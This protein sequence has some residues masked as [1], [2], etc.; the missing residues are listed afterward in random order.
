MKNFA[1]IWGA[2]AMILAPAVLFRATDMFIS[3][4][5]AEFITGYRPL[6]WRITSLAILLGGYVLIPLF[7]VSHARQCLSALTKHKEE[8]DH[9]SA[10]MAEMENEK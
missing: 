6:W 5:E 9:Y 7:A 10:V 8:P 1:K 2:G 3:Y 4:I